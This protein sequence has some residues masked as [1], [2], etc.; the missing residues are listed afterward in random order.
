MFEFKITVQISKGYP[1][2]STRLN[3]KSSKFHNNK[4][5]KGIVHLN[6]NSSLLDCQTA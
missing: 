2:T 4:I 5:K 1:L 3:C 6:E